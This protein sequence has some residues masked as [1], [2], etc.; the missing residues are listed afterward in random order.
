MIQRLQTLWILLA[1]ACAVLL[2][3][4]LVWQAGPTDATAGMDNIGAG[5]HPFLLPFAPLLFITHAIAIFSYKR[6]KRQLQWCNISIL[7]FT[8]FVIAS[9]VIL[10]LEV[11]ILT[12]FDIHEFRPGI[13]LPFAGIIFNAVAKRS[14]RKDEALVRS[15][16]RLR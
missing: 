10:Q 14:I 4:V 16:D 6:R 5:T 3:Y 9:V 11:Q 12:H 7:L 2:L 8:L 13:L 1:M 15:M